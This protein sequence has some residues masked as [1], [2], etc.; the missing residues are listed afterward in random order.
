LSFLWR[1]NSI[2][3][4]DSCIEAYA[5]LH[6]YEIKAKGRI[7]GAARPLI[8]FYDKLEQHPLVTLEEIVLEFR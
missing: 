3:S 1:V 2:S 4:R 8:D 6:H 7:S 5:P